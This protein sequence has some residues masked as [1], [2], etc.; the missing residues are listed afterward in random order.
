[1]NSWNKEGKSLEEERVQTMVTELNLFKEFAICRIDELM[2]MT[3][4]EGRGVVRQAGRAVGR[5]LHAAVPAARHPPTSKTTPRR[6]LP[7]SNPWLI[8]FHTM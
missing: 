3:V 2:R 5:A 1:M 7:I 4:V 6:T 8:E